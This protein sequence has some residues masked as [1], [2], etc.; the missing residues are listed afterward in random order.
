VI[1]GAG[2]QGGAC[3]I[4][5]REKTMTTLKNPAAKRSELVRRL[6]ELVTALD[7]RV[8]HVERSGEAAIAH[9]ASALRDKA[10]LRIAE[11]EAE[12]ASD[13]HSVDR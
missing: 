2:S 9:D 4:I 11:L 3:A 6:Q 7:Q 12:S 5:D 13:T 10:L 1:P 8:P